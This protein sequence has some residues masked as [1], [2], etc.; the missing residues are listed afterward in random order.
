MIH[1]GSDDGEQAPAPIGTSSR[2]S[3][4]SNVSNSAKK[5]SK[6]ISVEVCHTFLS[7]LE[8]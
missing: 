5:E 6:P 4:L 8:H 2:K 1:S 3:K 7:F